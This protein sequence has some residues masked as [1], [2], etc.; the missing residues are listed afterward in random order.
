[1]TVSHGLFVRRAAVLGAGVMGAQIAAHLV[2]AGVEAVL[3]DLPAGE[4]DASAT[5]RKGVEALRRLQPS[6]LGVASVADGIEVA[7]YDQHLDR[8]G[9][10]D[11]VI[12]A[13]AE[14]VDLK[15]AL[16]GRIAPHLAPHAVLA[17]NTSGLSLAA[18]ARGLPEALGGRFCGVHFFNPPR[19][20]PLVELISAP[21]TEPAVLDALESF[22]VSTLGK[23]VIRAHDTPN[24]IANRLG[25][26]SLL[27][28][29]HHAR[30][31]GLGFDEVDAVT[32][33]LMGRAKSAT[34]RTMDVVGLDTLGHVIET[35][36][37]QLHDDPWHHL[38]ALPDWL[39]TLLKDG[40]L[41]QKTGRGVYRKQGR[42]IQVLD[43][44]TGQYRPADRGA[45]APVVEILKGRDAAARLAAL[46]QSARPQARLLWRVT[47]D[48]LHYAAFHLH[49]IADNARDVD[50][51]MRWGYG[52]REG[53][54]E[55]WQAAGWRDVAR[56][57]AADL[58][59]GETL[60]AVPLPQWA[61][62]PSRTGVHGAHGS[63]SPSRQTEVPRSPLPVYG[64]QAMPDRVLGEAP[65][66]RHTVFETDAVRL[67][68]G[69]DDIAV[70]GFRSKLH[71]IGE[72][73]LDGLL[74]AIDE[75]E[76]NFRGLVIWQD[77]PPF[78]VGANLAA[79]TAP[80]AAA[81]KPSAVGAMMKRLRREAESA[82]LKAAHRLKVADALM[83]GRLE[84]VED[85][86]RQFQATALALRQARV[87]V[88][89]AVDGM[90]LGG[91]CEFVMHSARTVAA[92]E[93]YIG[94]VEVGV[95]LLPGAGGLKELTRRA[96]AEARGGDLFAPLRRAFEA[97][98]T[99][100]VSRSAAQA[101]ELGFLT[102]ADVIVMN[103]HELLHVARAQVVAMTES[104]WRPP[105]PAARIAVG[106]RT[107]IATFKAHMTNLLAG[108]FIS[109]HDFLV[110]SKVAE[111]L[112]GGDVDG[113]SLVDEQWLLAIARRAFMELLATEKTQAR[114]EHMLKTGKPLR[115]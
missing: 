37:T 87:P 105:A 29:F 62:D 61:A 69:G 6:P 4:G 12:E 10:C 35:M 25:A 96:A 15:H 48:M 70:I 34:F 39:Q 14:R 9:E 50:L 83:A 58:A 26:F 101:R 92:F 23:G 63:F 113:G 102:E 41:G 3:F 107:A 19:Y 53:P 32:G 103:R 2:N 46:R 106:G 94:L 40:A 18:L 76:R 52:W 28:L 72:D 114:I 97:V 22:L 56:W 59:A 51:A 16:Y 38:F 13:I 82:L 78:S 73:V 47:R 99:A 115:N 67:W 54:F 66:A 100:Q 80:R 91:G 49:G 27:A 21:H 55:L 110:G 44:A 77:E 42:D 71:A 79:P 57:I 95:G 36:R 111:V 20:M 17:T 60:A 81:A 85:M 5:A 108:G 43:P 88:V 86:L 7:N 33:T 31:L 24:F 65:S 30:V 109:E 84:K 93:S 68:S 112:C 104:G 89:A 75:A 45:D 8:L 98:A 74:Q 1:M 64:R 11:L 90:A